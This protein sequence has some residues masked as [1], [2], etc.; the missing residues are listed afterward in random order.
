MITTNHKF[1]AG[2][3]CACGLACGLLGGNIDGGTLALF[4]MVAAWPAAAFGY[5]LGKSR[6]IENDHNRY[7]GAFGAIGGG[8]ASTLFSTF[9]F[10][11]GLGAGW[12]IAPVLGS[13]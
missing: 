12:F 7:E 4:A 1:L 9:P 2:F 6:E 10:V 5:Y 11:L 3:A 13:A 8:F